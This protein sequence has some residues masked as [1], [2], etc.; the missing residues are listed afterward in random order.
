MAVF[1]L[2]SSK[3]SREPKNFADQPRQRAL[4]KLRFAVNLE[5]SGYSL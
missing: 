4:K 2:S 1:K 5:I 3:I